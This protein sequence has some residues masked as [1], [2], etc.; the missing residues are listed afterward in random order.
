M[1][2]LRELSTTSLDHYQSP[3]DHHG[4][5]RTATDFVG[6]VPERHI[7]AS[8]SMPNEVEGA[9]GV[10]GVR[11]YTNLGRPDVPNESVSIYNLRDQPGMTP[12]P[13]GTLFDCVPR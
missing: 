12:K 10:H 3:S 8:Y 7:D 13:S 4:S 5:R 6:H 11:L 2:T 9:K 1:G